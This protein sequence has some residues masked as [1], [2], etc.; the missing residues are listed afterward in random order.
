MFFFVCVGEE[1]KEVYVRTS[2]DGATFL[3]TDLNGND[4][5]TLNL[6]PL[7]NKPFFKHLI[8]PDR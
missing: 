6:L 5:T 8:E 3:T 1:K 7:L 4:M 2:T